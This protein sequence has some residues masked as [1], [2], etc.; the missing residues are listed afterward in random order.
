MF[1]FI[2]E[3]CMLVGRE[4]WWDFYQSKYISMLPYIFGTLEYTYIISNA[5]LFRYLISQKFRCPTSLS[6]IYIFLYAFGKNGGKNLCFRICRYICT[7]LKIR[8]RKVASSRPVYYSILELFGQRSQYIGMKFPL[9]KAS[10]NLKM[11]Y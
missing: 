2:S 6:F 9:H 7:Y 4:C 11:C 5:Y 3:E 8:Y 1:L 10:E